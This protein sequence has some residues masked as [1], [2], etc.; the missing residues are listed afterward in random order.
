M[1]NEHLTR[2]NFNQKRASLLSLLDTPN[3]DIGYMIRQE[4]KNIICVQTKPVE[5][6][7]FFGDQ[8]HPRNILAFAR[9]LYDQLRLYEKDQ[10]ELTVAMKMIGYIERMKEKSPSDSRFISSCRAASDE[11]SLQ[12]QP[13]QLFDASDEELTS[14]H[15]QLLGYCTRLVPGEAARV[16]GIKQLRKLAVNNGYEQLFRYQR[17]TYFTCLPSTHRFRHDLEEATVC[18]LSQL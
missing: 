12:I 4:N 11:L 2:K 5:Q 6:I 10:A 8:H 14:L 3:F 17:D 7:I 9:M 1:K 18:E 15:E 16:V 13:E